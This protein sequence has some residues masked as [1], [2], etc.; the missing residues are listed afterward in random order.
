LAQRASMRKSQ[1]PESNSL[2]RKILD[3]SD[4]LKPTYLCCDIVK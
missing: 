3:W 4:N 2:H 1:S